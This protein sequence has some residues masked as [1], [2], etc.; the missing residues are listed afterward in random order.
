MDSGQ[1]SNDQPLENPADDLLGYAGFAKNLADSIYNMAPPKGFVIALY[2]PWGSGKSTLL[3]FIEHNIT[4]RENE[5]I[6]ELI[7]YNPWWVSG[8]EDIALDLMYRI[9]EA[10]NSVHAISQKNIKRAIK[11]SKATREVKIPYVPSTNL[12]A[13]L[14]RLFVAD[15]H[16]FKNI[17]D[18]EL[19]DEKNKYKRVLVIIDDID[20]LTS[21]ETRGLFR[22]IKAI[23]DF[24]NTIYLLAFDKNVVNC[25]LESEQLS[26]N[27]RPE[28][29]GDKYL[30][31]IVQ[32]SIDI[33][34]ID[35]FVLKSMLMEQ[36]QKF[37]KITDKKL[38]EDFFVWEYIYYGTIAYFIKTPRDVN[39]FINNLSITYPRVVN[40]VNFL[41]F[42]IL[43]IFRCFKHEIYDFIRNNPYEFTG[44]FEKYGDYLGTNLQEEREKLKNFHQ[45]WISREPEQEQNTL[46]KLLGELFPRFGYAFDY[47]INERREISYEK[48]RIRT[49]EYFPYYFGLSLPSSGI[50]NA[51]MKRGLQ[52]AGS[53]DSFNELLINYSKEIMTGG[54][55]KA[56]VFLDKLR[57]LPLGEVDEKKIINIIYSLY[58]IGDDLMRAEETFV[59]FSLGVELIIYLIISESLNRFEAEKKYSILK[60][61]IENGRSLYLINELIYNHCD[62]ES[63]QDRIIESSDKI[64]IL[65]AISLNKILETGV[66]KIVSI[67]RFSTFLYS[68]R[69]WTSVEIAKGLVDR[70]IEEDKY[71]YRFIRHF[72][73]SSNLENDH[74]RI[75]KNG[76]RL[77]YEGLAK[78]VEIADI[79][80]RVK[81]DGKINELG[82]FEVIGCELLL[83]EYELRNKEEKEPPLSTS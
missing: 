74:E 81:G 5:E 56:N 19:N 75:K 3:N 30:D 20:R 48:A 29:I 47:N 11:I 55:T 46:K 78:F 26:D 66:D 17:I 4:E 36:I 65:K 67:P 70:I 58:S 10:L 61:A 62:K 83:K 18:K 64:N 80:D 41:D 16:K 77:S 32:F 50:S 13:D 7:R 34:L 8:R 69:D 68:F 51:E 27:S 9:L 25:A 49:E 71:M 54:S 52:S 40:E 63:K 24:R 57:F 28:G 2:G 42:F 73:T 37:T 6:P 15:V 53:I 14:L 21:E 23:G 60:S 1:L 82:E 76:L 33:P 22:A 59:T 72:L 39:V 45:D 38:Y 43:E 35:K 44:S 31:K 12:I 79:I